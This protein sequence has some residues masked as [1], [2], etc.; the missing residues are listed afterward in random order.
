MRTDSRGPESVEFRGFFSTGAQL[1]Y[2]GARG[3]ARPAP[4]LP[5]PTNYPYAPTML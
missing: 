5:H 3:T 1:T 4:T 2:L